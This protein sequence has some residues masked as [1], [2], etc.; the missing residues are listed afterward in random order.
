MVLAAVLGA[1][2]TGVGYVL[3]VGAVDRMLAALRE[4]VVDRAVRL[5]LD[6]IERVGSGDVVARTADDVTMLT[7]NLN[8]TLPMLTGALFAVV[9][10]MFGMA[11]LDWRL[12]A[13]LLM[14]L[15]VYALGI[16]M[17]RRLAPDM[18]SRERAHRGRRAAE[19]LAAL[20]GLGAV[21]AFGM[22]ERRRALIAEQSWAVVRL[23]VAIRIVN[24]RLFGRA[25]AAEWLG[26]TL[27]LGVGFLLVRGGDLTVGAVTAATLYFLRLFGPIG[28]LLLVIDPLSSAAASLRRIV[29]VLEYADDDRS[30]TSSDGP[31]VAD[32]HRRVDVE[33]RGVRC[34]YGEHEVLHGVDLTLPAGTTTAVVGMSGAG[35][36]TLAAVIAG[37]RPA[38]AGTVRVGGVD[39]DGMTESDR[40]RTVALVT[41]EVHVFAGTLRDDVAIADPSADDDR[42]REALAA[43]G[44]DEW[45]DALSAGVETIVGA[46]GVAL[47]PVQE[48]Q[49]ALARV[50]L[51]DPPVVILDEAT[52]EAGSAGA[53]ALEVAADRVVRGRTALVV[54][55]RLSQAA[56]ADRVVLMRDGAIVEA[57]THADLLAAGGEYADLWRSWSRGRS[58]P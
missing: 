47:T 55:H 41:Q 40:A 13:V 31:A 51:L 21:R 19:M 35:K 25:N 14:L 2:A 38:T 45:V 27:L 12:L 56:R 49:L 46:Q 6:R 42:V 23:A 34:A 8:E 17:Y 26:M 44:A 7:Q 3:L 9:V 15:P 1:A 29:G 11:A 48:Q 4:R 33:V 52:A 20:R 39:A 5:P 36:S 57:G 58:E 32:S 10:T 53:S 22:Q 54:A 43:V 50:V 18:Y 30:Q 24:N 16:R 28:S 37:A